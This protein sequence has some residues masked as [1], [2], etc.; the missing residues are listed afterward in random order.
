MRTFNPHFSGIRDDST[1]AVLLAGLP[2]IIDSRWLINFNDESTFRRHRE[3]RHET[4]VRNNTG[5]SQSGESRRYVSRSIL[6]QHV[7]GHPVENI[8]FHDRDME[9]I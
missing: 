4:R 6:G 2:L 1:V 8:E 5:G 7:R 9:L 3:A